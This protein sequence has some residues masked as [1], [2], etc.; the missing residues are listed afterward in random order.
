MENLKRFGTGACFILVPLV[1]IF[2]FA[3]HP[4]LADLTP[5]GTDVE[6]WVSEFHGNTLWRVGHIAV[7]WATIPMAVMFLSWMRLLK[8][9]APVLSF[10][11]GALGIVG[12]FALAAD[13]GALALVP[14]A[15]DTLPEEQFRQMLPGLRAML[16]YQGHL[17]MVQLYLLI[18]M[19]FVLMGIA[20]VRTKAVP[21]WQGVAVALGGLLLMNPDIDLISLIASLV[22]AIGMIPTGFSLIRSGSGAET[23]VRVRTPHSNA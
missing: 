11:A 4:N 2:A 20:L 5:P 1:L 6:K 22:L 13:K 16:Q 23:R 3:A 8:D 19:G 15:F 18:P 10:V 14:T 7:M 12:C 17:W 9:K 21:W